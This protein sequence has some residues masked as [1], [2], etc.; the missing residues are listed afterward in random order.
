MH[1]VA[2]LLDG[3]C[4]EQH[5]HKRQALVSELLGSKE[6]W[7]NI[8]SSLAQPSLDVLSL[9]I[10][11]PMASLVQGPFVENDELAPVSYDVYGLSAAGRLML[12]AAELAHTQGL[13]DT[14]PD[15]VQTQLL[16]TLMVTRVLCQYGL[17]VPGVYRL[18]NSNI[19]E[20]NA[21]IRTFVDQV[22]HLSDAWVCRAAE[23]VDGPGWSL[24]LLNAL[25]NKPMDVTDTL[26]LFAAQLAFYENPVSSDAEINLE[27][28]A[29]AEAFRWLLSKLLQTLAWTPEE[30]LRWLTLLK[31]EAT[32]GNEAM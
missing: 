13:Q 5:I 25:E 8:S 28:V 11:D 23:K 16:Q 1:R 15:N 7:Q 29:T 30:L 24:Q 10:H 2:T 19:T 12:F 6:E 9:T 32:T 17:G 31:A 18:W 26:T 14:L 4:G 20:C 27:E 3:F 22:Q 21:I